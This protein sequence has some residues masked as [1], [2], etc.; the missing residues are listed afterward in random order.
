M[1]VSARI[2]NARACFLF[3]LVSFIIISKIFI[4]VSYFVMF[5]VSVRRDLFVLLEYDNEN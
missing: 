4:A 2:Q 1:N 3:E 5:P